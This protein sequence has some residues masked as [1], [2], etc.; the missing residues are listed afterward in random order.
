MKYVKIYK[1]T[2]NLASVKA[3]MRAEGIYEPVLID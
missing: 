1:M 2:K 3:K